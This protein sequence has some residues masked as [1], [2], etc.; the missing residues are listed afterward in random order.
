MRYFAGGNRSRWFFTCLFLA[1]LSWT[2][3][4][5]ALE[6]QLSS[7]A[8]GGSDNF[9]GLLLEGSG[10]PDV[11]VVLMHGREAH[12]D[13]A[14][15]NQ[16]RHAI[17]SAGYT[18]LSIDNP[19]AGV[20][21]NNNNNFRDFA[22]YVADV[23][24]QAPDEPYAFP[25]AYARV[26]TAIGH[27]ES[28]G[29]EKVVVLGFS[30]GSRFGAAHV[31]RGHS[32]QLLPIVGFVGVGMYATSVD[33]LNHANTLPGIS[34]P[35][36]DLYGDDDSNAADTETNR[37]GAYGGEAL[38]Y[39]V[40]VLDCAPGL[41][42]NEC[43]KLTGLKSVNG[44]V[45]RPLE[46]EVLSWLTTTV[47]L[48]MPQGMGVCELGVIGGNETNETIETTGA[49]PSDDGGGVFGYWL[50]VLLLVLTGKRVSLYS[51]RG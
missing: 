15:V 14:V 44:E 5:S 46:N 9:T 25:E 32:D 27:L 13:G 42:V 40:V 36:L 48:A 51:N 49:G 3:P 8:Q 23:S 16:L 33:V 2:A 37:T 26:R 35:V 39:S 41:T 4:L 24:S 31:D 19:H 38:D 30:M 18:T 7:V 20:D 12:P 47:P 1:S 11:G 21:V 45:C 17:N 43:H 10:N 34:V 6:I 50:M 22:D 29:I 28:L